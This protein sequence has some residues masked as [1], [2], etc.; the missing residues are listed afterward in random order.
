MRLSVATS[1]YLKTDH[2][3]NGAGIF[4]ESMNMLLITH[5]LDQRLWVVANNRDVNGLPTPQAMRRSR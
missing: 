5:A 1:E 2:S 3:V 4:A